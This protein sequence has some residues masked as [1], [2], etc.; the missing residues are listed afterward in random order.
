M[1]SNYKGTL[2]R[3]FNNDIAKILDHF[4]IYDKI[5]YTLEDLSL[6]LNM[7]KDEILPYLKILINKNI[8]TTCNGEKDLYKLQHNALT[9][10]IG[11]F[12]FYLAGYELQKEISR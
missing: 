11:E 10:S 2:E 5:W 7:W 12:S 1:H 8:I 6:A 4:L 3:L 9:K